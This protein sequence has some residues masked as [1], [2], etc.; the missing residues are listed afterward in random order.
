[1]KSHY[2]PRPIYP[3]VG[4][5]PESGYGSLLAAMTPG[6]IVAADG[7]PTVDWS[8][9]EHGLSKAAEEEGRAIELI[10]VREAYP[11]WDEMVSRTADTTVGDPYFVK[12]YEG[13]VADLLTDLPVLSKPDPESTTV[14][15]GPGAALVANSDHV[16]YVDLPKR[17]GLT[18]IGERPVV[19]GRPDDQH[20]DFKRMVFIDWPAID[21]HRAGLIDD[22]DRFVD[23]LDPST[24][25]HVDG[26][27]MRASI[28]ALSTTPFRTVPHFMPGAWG[29]QWMKDTFKVHPDAKNLAW[30]YELIAPEA[31][32]LIGP[33]SDAAT[34]IPLDFV[35]ESAAAEVMGTDVAAAFG[36]S[37]P[38]RFDYLDTMDGTALSLHCHPRP[39][40]MKDVFGYPYTQLETYYMMATSPESFVYL[41]L[42]SETDIDEF[43][44]ATRR[45]EDDEVAFEITDYINTFPARKHDLLLIPDGTPHASGPGNV[46]LEISAT[47]YFYSLRFYDHLRRDAKG[48]PRPIH[49]DHAF[50]NLVRDRR[51]PAVEDLVA[52]PQVVRSSESGEEELLMNRDDMFFEIL[53]SRFDQ[54]FDD[55]TDGRFHLLA[56]VEGVSIEV[57]TEETSHILNYGE[58]ILVPAATGRYDLVNRDPDGREVMVVKAQ[59]G[60]VQPMQHTA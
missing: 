35:L 59:V 9:F 18:F 58:T 33:S 20:A 55:D 16:W 22:L 32:V 24:P 29:G 7:S 47:P 5:N 46:V 25:T 28:E 39:D 52:S 48:K 3:A 49:I 44:G 41:G 8:R 13:T 50:A 4:E 1:M 53:R 42:K 21:R 45:A 12:L 36:T 15:Y 37:F 23:L 19:L 10:D 57:N 14:V 27:T 54:S 34:E 60:E 11:S 40:Y 38:I 17:Y 31:G 30:S 2:E 56:L 26:P 6:T 51:G 43:E